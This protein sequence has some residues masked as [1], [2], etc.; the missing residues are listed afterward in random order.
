MEASRYGIAGW[1]AI[2]CSADPWRAGILASR[3][4]ASFIGA[5]SPYFCTLYVG[6]KPESPER[7]VESSVRFKN[8]S[9]EKLTRPRQ[10]TS[11]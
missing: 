1:W 10:R 5:P 4:A 2:L 11:C 7:S 6:R 9:E 3:S 8:L